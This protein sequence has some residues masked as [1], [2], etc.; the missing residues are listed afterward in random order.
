M[1]PQQP[2]P[3]EACLLNWPLHK[4]LDD[5]F[6]NAVHSIEGDQLIYD[7]LSVI[8][9]LADQYEQQINQGE[10]ENC[11]E[12]HTVS[13]AAWLMASDDFYYNYEGYH[14]EGGP[15]YDYT[16]LEADD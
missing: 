4:R 14:I 3:F 7:A 5:Q 6:H 11:Y 1:N 2:K 10:I 8:K 15:V 12:D 13:E 9:I 16:R